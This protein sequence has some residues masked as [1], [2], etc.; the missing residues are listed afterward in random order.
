ME[1]GA[2]HFEGGV[3]TQQQQRWDRVFLCRRRR[4][5][6]SGARKAVSLPLWGTLLR[7]GFKKSTDDFAAKSFKLSS[8]ANSQ[9]ASQRRIGRPA[10]LRSAG[11]L[12]GG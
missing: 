9:A 2:P 10:S 7:L 8:R 5:S 4:C 12:A 6:E 3:N 11:K 1:E